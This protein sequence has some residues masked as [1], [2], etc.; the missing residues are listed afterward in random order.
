MALL[1]C[2]LRFFVPTA[3]PS[4]VKTHIFSTSASPLLLQELLRTPLY[5][6][7]LEEALPR[8]VSTAASV[9]EGVKRRGREQGDI[10]D[11][12]TEE[13]LKPQ[14]IRPHRNNCSR[15]RRVTFEEM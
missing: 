8:V 6:S 11:S 7:A 9:L 10:M 1:L 12:A 2:D 3:C 15:G 5:A 4:S 14:A 13:A